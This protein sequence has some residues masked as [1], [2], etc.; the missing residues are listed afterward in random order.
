MVGGSGKMLS[1]NSLGLFDEC[2]L[3][4]NFMLSWGDF[5]ELA[6]VEILDLVNPFNSYHPVIHG[7]K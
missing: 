6:Y 1:R 7:K 2:D 3:L 5:R 4:A